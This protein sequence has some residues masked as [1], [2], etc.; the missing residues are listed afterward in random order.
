MKRDPHSWMW[1]EALDLLE[2]ADRMHRQFFALT[3]PAGAQ[4]R[5]EPPIDVVEG[6]NEVTVTIALPGVEPGR[7]ELQLDNGT[8]AVSAVRLP[9]A[10][11]RTTVIRRI[12]IPYG[13][14]ERRIAL[15]PGRYELL[16]QKSLNGCLHLRL[17]KS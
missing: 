8:L 12:E 1:A 17:R 16:E 4:V 15:P 14:F 7:I 13:R 2:Q 5:W 11:A 9:P 10:C 6:T 3:G